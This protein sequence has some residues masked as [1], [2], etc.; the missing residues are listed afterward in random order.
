MHILPLFCRKSDQKQRPL[1]LP[2][3]GYLAIWRP[4]LK[5]RG[6]VQGHRLPGQGSPGRINVIRHCGNST[7]IATARALSSQPSP[8]L[9][10]QYV[11]WQA[12]GT[13]SGPC[14]E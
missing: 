12:R 5:S 10:V 2:S 14:S 11:W 1:I 13:H 8:S 9:F 6:S 7:V 3:P 4:A